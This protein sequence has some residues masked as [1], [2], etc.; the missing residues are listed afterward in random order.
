[1]IR[2]IGAF[3]VVFVY[4]P[5]RVDDGSRCDDL[6]GRRQRGLARNDRKIVCHYSLPYMLSP[7]Y[8]LKN[9]FVYV[10]PNNDEYRYISIYNIS[11][12]SASN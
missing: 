4:Q 12:K 7:N 2:F 8:L 6:V 1:M 9:T 3:G 5:I 10:Y 11:V